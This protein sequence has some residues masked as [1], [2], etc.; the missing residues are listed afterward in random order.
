MSWHFSLATEARRSWA[1]ARASSVG[2]PVVSGGE[3]VV[4]AYWVA[5]DTMVTLCLQEA[6]PDCPDPVTDLLLYHWVLVV[7]GSRWTWMSGMVESE[8]VMVHL[9][10]LW[11]VTVHLPS[12]GTPLHCKRS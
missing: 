6:M 1:V 4:P 2:V 5:R 11:Q 3:A 9:T 8:L 12:V 7:K 10:C